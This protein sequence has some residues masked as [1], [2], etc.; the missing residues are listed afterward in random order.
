[1]IIFSQPGKQQIMQLTERIFKA[2]G[3]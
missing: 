2:S 1:L 3:W